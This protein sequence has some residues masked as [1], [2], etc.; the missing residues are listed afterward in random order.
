MWVKCN[1]LSGLERE[2]GGETGELFRHF[3][4]MDCI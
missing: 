3:V 2:Q 4:S 1:V